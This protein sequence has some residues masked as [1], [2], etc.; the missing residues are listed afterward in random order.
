VDDYNNLSQD[1]EQGS[2]S[3]KDGGAKP[4]TQK[5]SFHKA[6]VDFVTVR[7]LRSLS[8]MGVD[9]GLVYLLWALTNPCESFDE[10]GHSDHLPH[11]TADRAG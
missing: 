3:Q 9:Y 6:S 1:Q 5:K 11:S 2:L 7:F 10:I 8:R 4:V